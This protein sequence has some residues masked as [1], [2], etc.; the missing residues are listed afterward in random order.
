MK[1]LRKMYTN[2]YESNHSR[3]ILV[4]D[5]NE[6]AI[7]YVRKYDIYQLPGGTQD[8]GETIIDTLRREV[9]EEA[10]AKDIEILDEVGMIEIVQPDAFEDN[11]IFKQNNYCFLCR[12]TGAITSPKLSENEIDNGFEV[13]WLSRNKINEMIADEKYLNKEV[14]MPF[15]TLYQRDFYFLKEGLILLDK[16]LR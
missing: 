7:M 10:G 13:Q 2:V 3:A 14:E 1:L 5:K 4:N 12:T 6:V 15:K 11:K 9:Y 16:I 8:P